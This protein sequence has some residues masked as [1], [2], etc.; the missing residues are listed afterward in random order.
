MIMIIHHSI[1][2]ES[3]EDIEKRRLS[4]T[5][6]VIR[7][8]N[9]VIKELKSENKK[10]RPLYILTELKLAINY[11]PEGEA[12]KELLRDI[13][14]LSLTTIQTEKLD[15]VPILTTYTVTATKPNET[16][17]KK[18]SAISAERAG[19]SMLFSYPNHI[20]TVEEVEK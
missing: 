2:K 16:I 20:V 8:L 4:H 12:T 7:K 10:F 1:K 14:D 15:D 3:K 11:L 9:K 6:P 18:V 13:L 19:K 17:I 5:C